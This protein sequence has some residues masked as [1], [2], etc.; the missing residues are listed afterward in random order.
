MADFGFVG[1]SYTAPSIYQDAEELINWFIEIDQNKLQNAQTLPRGERGRYSMYPT[2]G[3]TLKV[4]PQAGEV[5]GMRPSPDGSKLLAVVGANVYIITPDWSAS[6]VGAMNT[7]SG[8]VHLTDNS[9]GSY[10]CDGNDRYYYNWDKKTLVTLPVTDGYFTGGTRADVVD[11]YIVY[12]NPGTLQWTSTWQ[13]QTQVSGSDPTGLM[14]PTPAVL[15]FGYG[16]K[17]GGPDP[18]SAL[19][20]NNRL[21]YVLGTK[22]SE[23]W[24]NSGVTPFAFTLIPGTSTQHGCAAPG[25]LAT[26]G[27][28]FAFLSQDERGQGL[29]LV[30]EGFNFTQISTHAVTNDILGGVISDATAFVYQMEGHE[31]YVLNFP[32]QDKT[33]VY[34]LST[35][36]WH[37][38]LSVD[39]RNQYHR[40]RANCS[41]MFQGQWV[42]GDYVNGKIYTL[43]NTIYTEDGQR[44]RRLRRCPHLVGDFKRMYFSTFQIQFQPGVGLS[45]GQ[46]K[47]P[48]AMLRWSNDGGS[49]W[50]SEVWKSIGLTGQ[51]QNRIIWRRLGWARDRIFEVSVTDPIKAVIVS[52]DLEAEQGVT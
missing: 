49:T 12:N 25:S 41:A 13:Y 45:T 17:T 37:K 23:V 18:I 3:L 26:F 51:Y 47:D 10:W 6:K 1:P 19:I 36:L 27:D 42:V 20:V 44:I 2:P 5:R 14:T 22:T 24:I 35:K 9:A 8:V 21:V 43:S 7:S 33:W 39:N 40:T 30:A 31:F 48:Q 11:G 34:D 28:S 52:A 32:S 16:N 29:V 46:G 38:W 50:S 15:P 4:T